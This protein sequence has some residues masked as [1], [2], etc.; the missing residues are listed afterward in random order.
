MGQEPTEVAQG[1]VGGGWWREAPIWQQGVPLFPSA[2][3]PSSSCAALPWC[4]LPCTNAH[5]RYT[6]LKPWAKSSSEVLWVCGFVVWNEGTL[7]QQDTLKAFKIGSTFKTGVNTVVPSTS[8]SL[9]LSF[10]RSSSPLSQN[11]PLFPRS[12]FPFPKVLLCHSSSFVFT[13]RFA[14]LI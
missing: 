7:N 10:P 12:I 5:S 6:R 11:P 9:P 8:P 1:W 4:P 2:C 13:P 14:P 3:L